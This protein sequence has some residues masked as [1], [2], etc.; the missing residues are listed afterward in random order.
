MKEDDVIYKYLAAANQRH[1]SGEILYKDITTDSGFAKRPMSLRFRF[2]ASISHLFVHRFGGLSQ[3]VG[4]TFIYG[5]KSFV[6]TGPA[7]DMQYKLAK[8][9]IFVSYCIR[10][11]P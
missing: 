7:I 5:G 9:D 11:S 2:F 3:N 10:D 4:V 1:P 8:V 6:D